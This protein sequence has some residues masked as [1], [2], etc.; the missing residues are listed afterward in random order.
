[1]QYRL[2]HT[3]ALFALALTFITLVALPRLKYPE[4]DHGDEWADADILL[5]GKNFLKFGF[6]KTHFLSMVDVLPGNKPGGF[7]THFPTFTSV[8]NGFLQL[9][10]HTDSI[11]TFR[12]VSIA[13]SFLAVVAWYFLIYTL[14]RSVLMAFLASIFYFANPIFIFCM[15]SLHE[16]AFS[17]CFRNCGLLFF[18]KVAEA[19]AHDRRRVLL[20]ILLAISLIAQTSVSFEYFFYLP[21]FF[22]L[23]GYLFKAYK[24]SVSVRTIVLL[25][26]LFVVGFLIHFLLVSLHFGGIVPAIHDLRSAAVRRIASSP[27][28]PVELTFSSWWNLVLVRDFSLVLFFNFVTLLGMILFSLLL[29][30]NLSVESRQRL[31]PLL[32]LLILLAICGISWYVTFPGHA[33]AHTYVLFLSRHLIPFAAVFFTLFCSIIFFFIGEKK[34]GR[35]S[36]SLAF[37]VIVALIAGNGILKSELPVTK[38]SIARAEDFKIFKECLSSFQKMSKES[39]VVGI[40]Y[41]RFAFM[42]YYTMRRFTPVTHKEEFDKLSSLP[43]Y[44]IYLPYNAPASQALL[45]ALKT[46]YEPMFQCASGRFPTLFLK[47]KQ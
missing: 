21:L 45:E 12:V 37:I 17:D 46:K 42:R 6:V 13:I 8:L 25:S 11:R 26:S 14:S 16:L 47:L 1:M 44:F 33:L 22:L 20:F 34:P 32:R 35:I 41:F 18:V 10:L 19:L 43:Q 9:V 3:L 7:Y 4:L 38:E 29:Y 15:D 27:D 36:S 23:F 30:G 40:N 39:D 5:A 2:K 31:K 24:G 28:S